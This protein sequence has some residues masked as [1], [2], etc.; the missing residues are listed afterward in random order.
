MD[1]CADCP[2]EQLELIELPLSPARCSH[3]TVRSESV[4]PSTIYG[5]SHR[6]RI[7][8]F[9]RKRVIQLEDELKSVKSELAATKSVQQGLR[10]R[11]QILERTSTQQREDMK[12]L[13]RKDAL[14]TEL[15]AELMKQ[16]NMSE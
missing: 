2:D 14:N 7:L 16:V 11:N 3:S 13:L 5:P 15:I 4:A 8:V 1:Y 6:S 10:A 9:D 12:M